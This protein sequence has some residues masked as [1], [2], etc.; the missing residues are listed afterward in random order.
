MQIKLVPEQC[1]LLEPLTNLVSCS[2]TF[3]HQHAETLWPFAKLP[4]LTHLILEAKQPVLYVGELPSSLRT[5]GLSGDVVRWGHQPRPPP[6]LQV[7]TLS[8]GHNSRGV[9][10][11]GS[12]DH[13]PEAET[14]LLRNFQDLLEGARLKCLVRFMLLNPCEDDVFTRI[15]ELSAFNCLQDAI[16]VGPFMVTSLPPSL[17]RLVLAC[18]R[19]PVHVPYLLGCPVLK[20]MS[21]SGIT[22]KKHV[23]V[24]RGCVVLKGREALFM[25]G[26]KLMAVGRP[27][28]LTVFETVMG[29][30]GAR[31][32]FADAWELLWHAHKSS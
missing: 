7:L 21:L 19:D 11:T 10:L 8:Q 16:V 25:G 6:Q 28:D 2:I 5:L 3:A 20:F 18:H 14:V 4:H 27:M 15:V 26:N 24:P 17:Q 13:V 31:S 23:A 32:H 29:N 12:V 22:A 30:L 1:Y 9:G